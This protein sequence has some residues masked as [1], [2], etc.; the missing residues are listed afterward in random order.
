[1]IFFTNSLWG[2]WL[3]VSIFKIK[4]SHGPWFINVFFFLDFVYEMLRCRSTK[5]QWTNE[6]KGKTPS[7]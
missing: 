2:V 5:G 6:K 7:L 1:L 3:E 4:G